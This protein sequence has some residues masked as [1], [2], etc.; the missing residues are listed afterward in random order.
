MTSTSGIDTMTTTLDTSD[1]IYDNTTINLSDL[2]QQESLLLQEQQHE[3]T[4]AVNAD[5]ELYPEQQYRQPSRL[6]QISQQLTK[7]K[8]KAFI[9]N[10]RWYLLFAVFLGFFTIFM[11]AYRR[12]F[13][14]A[15]ETLSNKLSDMGYSGYI[16]MSVLIFSSAFPPILGYGTYLTLSGFT[17]GFSIGFPISYLSALTGAIVCFQLSRTFLKAR[18]ARTLSKYPNLEAVVK[19]VEKKGFKLFLLIR[20]SPYPFNL[21][22]VFFAATNISLFQFAAG[23]A[24]SLLKIALHVYIGA[25]LTSFAKH[26]LGED[27][28]LSEVEQRVM[29]IRFAAAIFFSLLAFV[30]MAY[31]YRVAKAAVAETTNADEEQ[32]SFL[33]HHDEE[34]GFLDAVNEEDEVEEEH[35]LNNSNSPVVVDEPRDSVSLDAWDAWGDDS[36]NDDDHQQHVQ[37]IKKTA[38][39]KDD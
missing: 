17:F 1:E 22:N 21:L 35:I 26:V 16:L 9:Y 6:A 19:A 4:T 37:P 20:F 11:I 30:V 24:I 10:W 3:P 34:E 29:K 18:V 23:T 5:I 13:F 39:G 28:D 15:L 12:Q 2:A 31:L 27:G 25:N 36:D 38:I 8:I 33:N 32:M 7:R 14:E